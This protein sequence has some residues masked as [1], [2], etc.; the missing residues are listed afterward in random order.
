M[1]E[2][3]MMLEILQ[4]LDVSELERIRQAVDA[5][6]ERAVHLGTVEARQ[7][8]QE[9]HEQAQQYGERIAVLIER[10]DGVVTPDLVVDD[11]RDPTSPLHEFFEWDDRDA[12]ERGQTVVM[13]GEEMVDVR[14]SESVECSVTRLDG[15]E[16]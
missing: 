10:H 3:A 12:A 9:K 7:R 6:L 13:T 14:A 4:R 8:E 15:L 1:T 5:L 2:L 16:G 11:A